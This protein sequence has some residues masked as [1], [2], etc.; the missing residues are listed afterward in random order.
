MYELGMEEIEIKELD[1]SEVRDLIESDQFGDLIVELL[2][3][4]EN[5]GPLPGILLPFIEAFFS[6][7]PLVVFVITNGAAYGLVKGF[8]YSWIGASAG[9]L[10][11][12]III[13]KL[14]EKRFLKWIKNNKQV[15]RVTKWLER[16]GF[17]PLFLLMCFPFSPSAIINI[18]AGLSKIN[19]QQF[20]L[21]V[22]LG[23]AVMILSI[24][25]IGDSI[26]SF[27]KEPLKTILIGVG[28]V[29]FWII[30]KY[31]EKRLQK[32]ADAHQNIGKKGD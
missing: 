32:R 22:L 23:K 4:Y 28:I 27:A 8:L 17:G 31:I 30:G 26:M 25:T 3:S 16:H 15:R 29:L 5:L 9:A 21:A 19:F 1:M 6:F 20:A 13:R 24:A 14:G 18:V 12:F 7:L 10:C 11:V 2:K